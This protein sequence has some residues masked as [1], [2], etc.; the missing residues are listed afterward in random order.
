MSSPGG[1][2]RS[3]ERRARRL[4]HWYPR[5][6]RDRY[7]DE[8]V[9]LLVD[10]IT[11]R[12]FA[13]GRCADVVR[14]GLGERLSAE[15]RGPGW[16][17]G[18]VWI[19]LAG[20]LAI[21][22][23]IWSQLT[24]D[25]QFADPAGGSAVAGMWL[26]SAAL[27]AF[28]AL[29]ALAAAPVLVALAGALCAGRLRQLALPLLVAVWGGVMLALGSRHFGP[30]WPGSGGHWWSARGL[31]PTPVARVLWAGTSWFSSYWLHPGWLP[32]FPADELAWMAFSPIALAATLTGSA[33]TVARLRLST[34]VLRFEAGV[35]AL[36]VAAMAAFLAGAASW[37]LG[38]PRYLGA[39][40]SVGAIDYVAVAV[41]TLAL[42]AATAAIRRAVR[43][44]LAR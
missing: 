20:F 7:G 5:G 29:L 42:L 28:A 31:V 19:A 2:A 17:L 18:L 3:A 32:H 10:D 9:A 4:V 39:M 43:V 16:S 6:W 14:C 41:M 44:G 34:R 24:I 23:A 13:P 38:D 21:G 1:P 8:F 36:G 15:G 33:L 30:M 37:V 35:A 25:W 22:V 12:P 11:E 26:M 27:L 40:F